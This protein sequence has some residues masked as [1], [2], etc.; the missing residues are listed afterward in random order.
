MGPLYKFPSAPIPMVYDKVPLCPL[1]L[2]IYTDRAFLL[3]SHTVLAQLYAGDVQAC[4]HSVLRLWR[5]C[6]RPGYEHSHGGFGNLDVV[7]PD[8]LQL[9]EH[10]IYL[11]WLF[12]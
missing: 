1:L 12:L 8:P 2:I 5:L 7:Q 3:T 4:Q 10:S 6:E 11:A 9:P